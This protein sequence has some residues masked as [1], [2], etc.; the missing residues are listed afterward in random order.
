MMQVI[1]SDTPVRVIRDA[2][3]S[4]GHFGRKAYVKAGAIIFCLCARLAKCETNSRV[5]LADGFIGDIST[6]YLK[7]LSALELL[8]AMANEDWD[9]HYDA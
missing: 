5:R 8:G 6:S 2:C 7:P 3:V 9:S 4:K 1:L